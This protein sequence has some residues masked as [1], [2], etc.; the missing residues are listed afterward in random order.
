MAMTLEAGW[1]DDDHAGE[2]RPDLV[3][4]DLIQIDF[5]DEEVG[6]LEAVVDRR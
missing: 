4:T 5:E 6:L 1:F 3:L 2:S